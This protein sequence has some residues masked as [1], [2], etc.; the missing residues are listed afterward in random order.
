M[1]VGAEI[2]GAH[3]ELIQAALKEIKTKL[4]INGQFVDAKCGK[5]FPVEV[6]DVLLLCGSTERQLTARAWWS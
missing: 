5:T 1:P 3:S 4:L 6:R 2:K